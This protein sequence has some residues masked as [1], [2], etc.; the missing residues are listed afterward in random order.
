MTG[1]RLDIDDPQLPFEQVAAK[2]RAAIEADELRVGEQ[3]ESVRTLAQEYGVSTG[4]IQR[5]VRALREEGL[6]TSWQGRGAFVRRKPGEPEPVDDASTG[7]LRRIVEGLAARLDEIER[8]LAEL[9][10]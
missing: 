3:L 9:R 6:V 1:A 7:E 10:G 8:Q 4:T 5:A 2:I